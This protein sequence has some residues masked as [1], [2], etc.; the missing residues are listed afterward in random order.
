MSSTVCSARLSV[1]D[2][3]LRYAA[4]GHPPPLL[5]NGERFTVLDDGR[6]LPLCYADGPRREAEVRLEGDDILA[7][8]TDGLVESPQEMIDVGIARLGDALVTAGARG[9][10]RIADVVIPEALAG[11]T[12]RDDLALVVLRLRP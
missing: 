11:R 5:V 10:D 6:S 12:S 7:L 3:K 2:G 8:Y 9:F 4:A 1:R